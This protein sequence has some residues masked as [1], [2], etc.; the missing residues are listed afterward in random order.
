MFFGGVSPVC[1]LVHMEH[2]IP[3]QPKTDST[4]LA[5]IVRQK[6]LPVMLRRRVGDELLTHLLRVVRSPERSAHTYVSTTC[7]LDCPDRTDS[8]VTGSPKE[9]RCLAHVRKVVGILDRNSLEGVGRG[10]SDQRLW[11][12]S[13]LAG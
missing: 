4:I 12:S 10:Y 2:T 5:A 8:R 7:R 11:R 3:Q 6:K 1:V 13:M 9:H